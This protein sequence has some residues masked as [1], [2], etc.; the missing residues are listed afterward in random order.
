MSMS[1]GFFL[2]LVSSSTASA[3]WW[4]ACSYDSWSGTGPT[5]YDSWY[6]PGVEAWYEPGFRIERRSS[7]FGPVGGWCEPRIPRSAPRFE[8]LV[9]RRANAP[10]FAPPHR[11]VRRP[12]DHC[13][14]GPDHIRLLTVRQGS[15]ALI[16]NP[17]GPPHGRVL[18]E[19][20]GTFY[21]GR[22]IRFASDCDFEYYRLGPQP[23]GPAPGERS[24]DDFRGPHRPAPEGHMVQHPPVTKIA[25]RTSGSNRETSL[26]IKRPCDRRYFRIGTASVRCIHRPISPPGHESGPSGPPG[27]H[28][29]E[30]VPQDEGH[31]YDEARPPVHRPEPSDDRFIPRE[32]F[33]RR[34]DNEPMSPG[35]ESPGESSRPDDRR[36]ERPEPRR[37][38]PPDEG[39]ERLPNGAAETPPET[40]TRPATPGEGDS[41]F[42]RVKPR[43]RPE[44]T[45]GR[46]PSPPRERPQVAPM[47]PPDLPPGASDNPRSDSTDRRESAVPLSS[48]PNPV[49]T[50]RATP[51]SVAPVS[52]T[53]AANVEFHAPKE[54]AA[55]AEIP[56]GDS[57]AV[58]MSRDHLR[59][60]SLPSDPTRI[61]VRSSL[62]SSVARRSREARQ[63]EQNGPLEI[64]SR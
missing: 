15:V 39:R 36:D 8:P 2:A 57:R 21:D 42:L 38:V 17:H 40:G 23:H 13:G 20:C 25:I 30:P 1:L 31:A 62:G 5:W 4:E 43:T 41:R 47:D 27:G 53:E 7:D 64:V 16:P 14:C 32:R 54:S 52:G 34:R 24:P 61:R 49:V 60:W 51:A 28:R 63:S 29:P 9:T 33:E 11:E 58:P 26:W 37:E 6:S 44:P 59:T 48:A 56:A 3:Q 46:D 12:I 18:L 22:A 45:D 19:W 55:E 35:R 10:C 50:R